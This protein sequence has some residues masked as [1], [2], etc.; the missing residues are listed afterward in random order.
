[1]PKNDNQTQEV[2]IIDENS[3]KSK[4]YII[5]GQKVMLDADLAVIYGYNTKNFNQQVQRNKIKFP[6]D[7]MFQLTK[8]EIESVRSPFVA[9]PNYDLS[10]CQNVTS[11]EQNTNVSRFQNGTSI[12]QT[13]GTKGGGYS[14]KDAGKKI[15]SIIKIEDNKQLYYPLINSLL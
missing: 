11:I 8:E 5:R 10:R 12:M 7:M 13:K 4:I 1:M 9:S 3:L 14:S 6:S 15:S 2:A